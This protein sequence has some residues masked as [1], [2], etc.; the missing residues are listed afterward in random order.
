M[1]FGRAS[2]VGRGLAT[3]DQV[4]RL[5]RPGPHRGGPGGGP[6]PQGAGL[7]EPL[8]R[9][10]PGLRRLAGRDHR[11][12]DRGADHGRGAGFRRAAGRHRRRTHRRLGV[13]RLRP[14]ARRRRGPTSAQAGRTQGSAAG[15]AAR[16]HRTATAL[17]RALRHGRRSRP[18]RPAGCRWRGS[19]PSRPTRRTGLVAAR[20]GPRPNV[21]VATNW[22]SAPGP[23]QAGSSAP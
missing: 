5:P 9:H 20:P 6:Y 16:Y 18:S 17:R 14:A 15:A 21:V 7:D 12:R 4:R 13:L 1:P 22:S 3:R 10:R 19:S 11:R 23:I 8:W 2:T